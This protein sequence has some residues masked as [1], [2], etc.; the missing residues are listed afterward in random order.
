[1]T[2][3]SERPPEAVSSAE[4]ARGA[5][6]LK[7]ALRPLM[8]L[9]ALGF[10]AW[11]ARDL[12]RS[13]HG[14]HVEIAW[15]LV[16]ASLVPVAASGL[17]LAFSWKLLLER[18]TGTKIAAA[19]AVA[20]HAESQL[21]RYVPGKVGLPVVRMAGAQGI[22]APA[23]AVGSSILI[24]ILS[25]L[26][27][28]GVTGLGLLALF[29]HE[30]TGVAARV[31]RVAP[32]LLLAFALGTLLLV[33]VDRRRF[34]AAWVSG[35]GLGGAGPLVPARLPLL[36]VV[37]WLGW[38]GHGVL[39]VLAVGGDLAVGLAGSGLF[40]IAP[41]VGFLALAAPAGAGVREA[42]LSIGLAPALGAP[43]AVVVI[44][45]SR[46]VTLLADVLLWLGTRRHRATS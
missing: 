37:Y 43:Q 11:A 31:G 8:A 7:R 14:G 5:A 32:A 1:M 36:H 13:W 12:V 3:P 21:A 19:P 28:G 39:L 42:V 35:L 17:V 9:V 33:S 25:F 45:A 6:R 34:P 29:S 2:E 15:S 20:L 40:V 24:E 16:A 22:G 18:M 4:V 10:I 46:A 26:A 38:A 23:R 30:T 41:I 44:V 27:V